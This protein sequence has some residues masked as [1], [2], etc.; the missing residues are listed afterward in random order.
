MG[1]AIHSCPEK[2][3]SPSG[4]II[5]NKDIFKGIYLQDSSTCMEIRG[6]AVGIFLLIKDPKKDLQFS[7]TFK[8]P[9]I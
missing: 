9:Q 7:K 5:H 8:L 6:F 4:Y 2:P 1:I 3:S